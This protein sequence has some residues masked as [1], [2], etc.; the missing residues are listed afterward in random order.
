MPRLFRKTQLESEGASTAATADV[1]TEATDAALMECL[2]RGDEVALDEVIQRWG[3][4]VRTYLGHLV[5]DA[6]WADDLTQEVFVRVFERASTYNPAWSFSV[7]LF[8]IARN[9]CVDLMRREDVHHRA[10]DSIREGRTAPEG[11]APTASQSRSPLSHLQDAELHQQY[12]QALERLP[13]AFRSVFVLK[14][15]EGL[16]YE[17]IAEVVGAPVKT[18][19]SRLHRARTQLR[20]QLTRYL[21]S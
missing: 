14:E 13:E 17:E 9:L 5:R 4:R 11:T 1:Y 7:W 12:Q 20:K 2:T 21:D 6:S 8:R 15:M 10:M 19:S 3:A 16:S 18:V